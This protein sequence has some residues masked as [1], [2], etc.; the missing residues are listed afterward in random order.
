MSQV[1]GVNDAVI[2]T[3]PFELTQ[4]LG[5]DDDAISTG[6]IPEEHSALERSVIVKPAA[7]IFGAGK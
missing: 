2:L 7:E 3:P 6:M 4:D 5:P 1:Q